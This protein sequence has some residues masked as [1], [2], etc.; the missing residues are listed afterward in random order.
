ML[1]SLKKR[2]IKS[3][4]GTTILK[5]FLILALFGITTFPTRAQS[6]VINEIMA[7]NQTTIADDDGD[8][9]DWIEIYNAGVLPVNLVGYGL[10][11]SYNNPFKWV[12]P[13][14]IIT[15]GQFL[16]VWASNKNRT[17][18]DAP[19]HTNYA[20]SAGGE[21]VI[22]THPNG[23]RI[24]EIPP[25]PMGSDISFGH[26]PDASGNL[27]F[28]SNPTP[29]ASND[30]QGFEDIL[31]PPTLS[32]ASGYYNEEQTLM[33]SH[34]DPLAVIYYTL[35][36]NI[37]TQESIP[38]EGAINI[39][40]QFSNHTGIN[41]I[42]TNPPEADPLGFGWKE[43]GLYPAKATVVRAAAFR[44]SYFTPAPATA[45]YFIGMEPP[46]LPVASLAIDTFHLFNHYDGIYIP[47]IDY[48]TF[49]YG[50]GFYGTPNANYFRRG[51]LWEV[52]SFFSFF[53][54]GNEVL[55]ENVGVRIHGGGTR[56]MPQKS[57]RIYARGGYGSDYLSH[58]FFPNQSHSHYKRMILRNA[59]QDFFGPGTHLRDGFIQKLVEPIGVPI[60]DYRPAIL[61][62]NGEYWGIQNL[63]ERYD[64][65]YFERKYG[66]PEGQLELMEDELIV[67]EG[68]HEHFWA[69]YN[70]IV[71]NPLYDPD[72]YAYIQ[73]QMNVENFTDYNIINIFSGNIDW[74]AHNLK[75]FRRRTEYNPDAPFG[76]DGRWHWALNDLDF[77][78]SWSGLYSYQYDMIAY[79]TDPEG[80]GWP[81]NWPWSTLLIRSLL[82][83][84]SFR[85]GFINRFADLLNTVFQTDH[86]LAFLNET[87]A[88]I[89]PEIGKHIDRWA[90]PAATESQW[91]INLNRLI[92]FATNRPSFQKTHIINH[93]E[94]PGTFNLT[95]DV[96]SVSQGTVMVNRLH[97]N[98]S[99][100]LMPLFENYPYTGEYFS[101]VPLPI[102]AIPQPGFRLQKW[103]CGNGEEFFENPLYISRV[104]DLSLTAIFEVDD[105][106][107]P[108]IT[109]TQ[110][111]IFPNPATS[112]LFIAVPNAHT[113]FQVHILNLQ[114]RVVL[115]REFRHPQTEVELDISSLGQ[116]FYFIRL[117]YEG[118][119]H[120]AMFLKQ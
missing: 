98:A 64:R 92:N 57:L 103:V 25:T 22:L 47:G 102:T 101:G 45:T 60:Q 23:T 37:P 105:T 58:Q 26:Q 11:D 63:R 24:S 79:V 41:M 7:S 83:N 14:V 88:V 115:S 20:I 50:E 36:G 116:G 68:S 76:N 49:G 30:Q 73:T 67:I 69:M 28:F 113:G 70:Y 114:G 85:N 86:M 56:A 111:S 77:G 4:G 90:Y 32:L 112:R 19:L 106:S 99:N 2:C 80:G 93:F 108:S 44:E 1:T 15:P 95:L 96:N 87:K 3:G 8:Y 9:P 66:I 10:S 109:E 29:G 75:Y 52:P 55:S 16:L 104:E 17:N 119:A 81:P 48:E 27:V 74:P 91:H 78:F 97:L 34:P 62:L 120:S 35:D 65:H 94:L 71:D 117:I 110:L 33:I 100:P 40:P 51:E 59:G 42:R 89:E 118:K 12:F 84:E 13:E 61:Y 107:S 39:E 38:Y 31:A 18:P 46:T 54:E 82:E 5:T 21:E 53:E 43:P 6:L 72:A